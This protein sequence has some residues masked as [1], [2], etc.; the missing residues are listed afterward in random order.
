MSVVVPGKAELF[1][2]KSYRTLEG[3]EDVIARVPVLECG[4][5]R[6]ICR[7]VFKQQRSI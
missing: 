1:Y 7:Q 6:E 2:I 3:P 4:G 5:A